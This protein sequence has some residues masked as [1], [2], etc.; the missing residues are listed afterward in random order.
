MVAKEERTESETMNVMI[1]RHFKSSKS[2][3][4]SLCR[5]TDSTLT[6]AQVPPPL[7]AMSAGAPAPLP[8]SRCPSPSSGKQVHFFLF[9][10]NIFLPDSDGCYFAR[11]SCQN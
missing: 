7:S 4:A 6:A 3:E 1:S 2:A 11:G 5:Q 8:H 9:G 10:H